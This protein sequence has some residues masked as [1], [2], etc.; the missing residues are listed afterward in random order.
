MTFLPAGALQN[1]P[2]RVVVRDIRLQVRLIS[3]MS[4]ILKRQHQW[5]NR[6]LDYEYHPLAV[7]S[8]LEKI[9]H[10]DNGGTCIYFTVNILCTTVK[11]LFNYVDLPTDEIESG[12]ECK[13]V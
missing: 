8:M 9:T 10:I 1:L 6:Q 12:A 3:Q 2:R 4:S 11:C 5:P 7:P 13:C